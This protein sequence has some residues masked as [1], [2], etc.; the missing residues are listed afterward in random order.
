METIT[1]ITQALRQVQV[2]LMGTCEGLTQEQALW[3]PTNYSNLDFTHFL[4]V[5]R[6]GTTSRL[7]PS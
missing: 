6:P 5:K 4:K 3:R 7:H 1:F 2:R